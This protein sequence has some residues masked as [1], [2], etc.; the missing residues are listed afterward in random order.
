[1]LLVFSAQSPWLQRD[2]RRIA[3]FFF[4]HFL[5]GQNDTPTTTHS[6]IKFFCDSLKHT[7]KFLAGHHLTETE[8]SWH[9]KKWKFSFCI[10]LLIAVVATPTVIFVLGQVLHVSEVFKSKSFWHAICFDVHP[11]SIPQ[12]HHSCNGVAQWCI[13]PSFHKDATCW[14]L[15]L[16]DSN[17]CW[18]NDTN[19]KG[20]IVMMSNLPTVRMVVIHNGMCCTWSWHDSFTHFH[21]SALW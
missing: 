16:G 11:M 15:L 14:L 12:R 9:I 5:V 1:M 10:L 8:R 19:V 7:S 20:G 6:I 3:E 13:K 17:C 2:R 4:V 21:C 18:H